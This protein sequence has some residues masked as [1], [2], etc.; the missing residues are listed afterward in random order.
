MI[1]YAFRQT[2]DY[3]SF[4][5]WMLAGLLFDLVALLLALPCLAFSAACLR[6]GCAEQHRTPAIVAVAGNLLTLLIPAALLLNT[7]L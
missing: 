2:T 1:A 3:D 6:R 5:N 7:R 4:M